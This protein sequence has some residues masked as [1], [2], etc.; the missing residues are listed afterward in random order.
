MICVPNGSHGIGYLILHLK[1]SLMA[2]TLSLYSNNVEMFYVPPKDLL[3]IGINFFMF[4]A[5][6]LGEKQGFINIVMSSKNGTRK[7]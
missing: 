6:I 4:Q 1:G 7:D 2:F 5:H 3:I